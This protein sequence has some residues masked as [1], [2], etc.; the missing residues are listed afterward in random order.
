MKPIIHHMQSH[1]LFAVN[2]NDYS[3]IAGV[4][5]GRRGKQRSVTK[6]ASAFI[7][8]KIG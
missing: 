2:V 5:G 1:L 4:E 6:Q 7:T 3:C 8:S